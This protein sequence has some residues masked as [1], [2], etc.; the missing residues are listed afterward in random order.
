MRARPALAAI[1]AAC[2]AACAAVPDITFVDDRDASFDAWIES[3]APLD[4]GA[5][6][7]SSDDAIA[8][9]AS[10]SCEAGIVPPG[11]TT[12]CE[13]IPCSGIC[14]I[15]NCNKCKTCSVTDLCCGKNG[16]T[17]CVPF[18]TPCPP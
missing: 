4:A 16:S 17:M 3:G 18:G 5:N 14:N 11:A 9:D 2:L 13:D 10:G 6:D 8:I 15:A 1:C 12:C 7:G